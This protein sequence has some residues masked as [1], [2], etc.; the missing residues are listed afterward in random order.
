MLKRRVVSGKGMR[1][2]GWGNTSEHMQVFAVGTNLP[3]SSTSA[4]VMLGCIVKPRTGSSSAHVV[5]MSMWAKLITP[6]LPP[7][8]RNE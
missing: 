7:R 3:L 2:V 8:I 5:N 1:C 6:L 4:K